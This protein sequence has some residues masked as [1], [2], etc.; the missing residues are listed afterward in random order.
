M[1]IETRVIKRVGN[2]STS[3]ADMVDCINCNNASM[4]TVIIDGLCL[5]CYVREAIEKAIQLSCKHDYLKLCEKDNGRSIIG[6][7]FCQICGN[8]KSFQYDY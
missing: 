5:D 7:F 4:A 3:Q 2:Y 1:E 8:I 6:E